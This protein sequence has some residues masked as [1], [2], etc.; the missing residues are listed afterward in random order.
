[1]NKMLSG[2][3]K[4][5]LLAVFV[6]AA[7]CCY[8]C[9]MGG[10]PLGLSRAVE[11]ATQDGGFGAAG[12]AGSGQGGSGAAGEPGSVQGGSG[13]AG[14]PEPGARASGTAAG[15]GLENGAPAAPQAYFVH[16]CGAVENPG[17][18]ELAEGQRVYEAVQLAG[19]FTGEAAADFINL[20]EPVQDGMK[21][22][23]PEKGQV[24]EE[25][26]GVQQAGAGSGGP[27]DAARNA[28]SPA[29]R[30]KV[31]INTAAK[32]ELM[33]LRGIGEARAEDIIRFRQERGGFGRI[34]DI[35]EVSGIKDAAFQKI[36]DDITV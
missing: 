14:E 6:L 31:N 28:S 25:G 34:E 33:T 18:Y 1:M 36:K 11:T 29:G 4:W 5:L 30:Q 26:W 13:A 27:A 15:P 21:I 9:G 8:S 35:M 19:G 23:V 7:G 3:L 16:V 17:V 22:M 2:V 32:E 20:A 10:Q 24:P 12:E